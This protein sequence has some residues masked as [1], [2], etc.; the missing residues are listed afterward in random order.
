MGER[1]LIGDEEEVSRLVEQG[2]CSLA[3][4]RDMGFDICGIFCLSNCSASTFRREA[5]G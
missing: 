2:C 1:M 4:L 3:R 5:R